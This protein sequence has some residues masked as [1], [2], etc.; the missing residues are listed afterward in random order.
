MATLYTRELGKVRGLAKG[1]WRPKSGFYAA[2]DLL[3]T[4]QVLV[5]RK[6]SG[7]LDVLTEA[8]LEQRFRVGSLR[9]FHGALYVAELLDA[10]TADADPQP[11][12]FDAAHATLRTLSSPRPITAPDDAVRSAGGP[13][14]DAVRAA[15]LRFELELLRIIGHAPALFR[16][17]ECGAAV[18]ESARTFFAM[19]DGGVLCPACRRG[20]R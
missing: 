18:G 15:L 6:Y 17:A 3:S 10:L 14:D 7:G 9:A 11:D 20:K 13:A 4:C 16:C 8:T 19:L 2:L 12:L 5:L 1:A